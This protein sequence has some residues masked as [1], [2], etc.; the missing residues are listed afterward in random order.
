ME[1][2]FKQFAQW[3]AEAEK[4]GIKDATAMTL[5]T[6]TA[7]GKPSARIVLLKD[8]DE[9][10]FVFYTNA[11]SRKGSELLSNPYAALILYWDLLNKQIRIE[12][13]VEEVK[14]EEA[15]RYFFS[16]HPEKQYGAWASKQSQKL[17]KREDLYAMIE[18]YK[19]KFPQNPPRPPHWHG[20][21]V[22]PSRIE[23][24][25][26]GEF[27]LHDREVFEKVDNVWQSYKLYP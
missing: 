13:K 5:A 3:F 22:V 18:E 2:P 9:K 20:F 4:S 15:D 19:Q 24:W 10:G 7:D 26:D 14:G 21:R 6:A 12:G 27:R 8:F 25:Q 23:F 11:Q 17:E 16:R 1:K